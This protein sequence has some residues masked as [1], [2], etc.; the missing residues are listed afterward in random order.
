MCKHD[1]ASIKSWV[2]L[3][4]FD[5]YEERKRGRERWATTHTHTVN[6]NPG[7]FMIVKNLSFKSNF[8]TKCA[9]IYSD[10]R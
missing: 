8:V 5:G 2:A 10:D 4:S 1:W 3:I 7:D 6:I 9:G